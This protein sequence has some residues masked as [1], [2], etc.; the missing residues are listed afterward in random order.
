ML[1]KY[2]KNLVF[3][4]MILCVLFVGFA[5]TDGY[6][7]KIK[8]T[9]TSKTEDIN[10]ELSNKIEPLI[11]QSKGLISLKFKNCGFRLEKLVY[12]GNFYI[13]K[14]YVIPQKNDIRL[15]VLLRDKKVKYK[16][17]WVEKTFVISF[18]EKQT[19]P[20]E[21][22]ILSKQLEK[23]LTENTISLDFK[24]ADV[25]NILRLISAKTGINIIAGPDIKGTVTVHFNN[26]TL[27]S[28]LDSILKAKGYG[29]VEE[30]GILRVVSS[31]KLG[32]D[33]IETQTK[34]FHLNWT[35]AKEVADSIK[36]LLTSKIGK[37]TINKG[38]N[39]VIVTDTPYRLREI[40]RYIKTIDRKTKQVLIEARMVNIDRNF[41]RDVGL[42][43]YVAN[44]KV[45][46]VFK[47]IENDFDDSDFVNNMMPVYNATVNGFRSPFAYVKDAYPIFSLGTTITGTDL[48]FTLNTLE[49]EGIVETLQAP[50]TIITDNN[51]AAF[52]VVNEEPYTEATVRDQFIEQTV[53]FKE[54]G[55]KLYV[56]PHITDDEH[57]LME[58]EAGQRIKSG[59]KSFS[60]SSGL[61]NVVPIVDRRTSKTTLIM[62][63]KEPFVVGGF[64]SRITDNKNRGI[65]LLKDLPV[66]GYLF[67][68][69]KK[70]VKQTELFVFITPT[71]LAEKNLDLEEKVNYDKFDLF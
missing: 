28:A 22:L 9:Y 47:K 70:E 23:Q 8:L 50:K 12:D 43:W 44:A 49:D 29:Y 57:I 68:A 13:K 71:I 19:A 30:N 53:K 61:E 69:T 35:V 51:R 54:T 11:S 41:L 25:K 38:T 36:P 58:V 45:R 46:N 5:K 10:I 37:V 40:E 60:G 52:E 64:K 1:S 14:V 4:Q 18:E 48:D 65:P 32:I 17:H 62:K 55:V 15:D 3:I 33:K 27:K 59:E 67:K 56:T 31:D 2:F 7:S 42:Y 21:N 26:V 34:I 20:Y 39:N 63:N 66:I 24:N 16:T 6:I